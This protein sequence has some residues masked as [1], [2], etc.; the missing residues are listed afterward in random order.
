MAKT[1]EPISVV[2]ATKDIAKTTEPALPDTKEVAET[3][4]D[5]KEV[6][7]TAPGTKEVAETIPDAKE[8]AE[9]APDT[10]E[11]AK[12]IPDTKEVAVTMQPTSKAATNLPKALVPEPSKSETPEAEPKKPSLEPEVKPVEPVPQQI[13]PKIAAP[14][15]PHVS[16]PKAAGP[17]APVDKNAGVQQLPWDGLQALMSQHKERQAQQASQMVEPVVVN[18]STHRKEGMRLKRLMEESSQ[19]AKYPHMKK[20]FTEGSKEAWDLN[21]CCH[22]LNSQSYM[23]TVIDCI[24]FAAGA[25][26]ASEALGAL[27]AQCRSS[28]SAG[29]DRTHQGCDGHQA[30]GALER[31]RDA[32]Q[33]LAE[34]QNRSYREK[35][36]RHS[37]W[38]LSR[39]GGML[40]VLG[41]H[42]IQTGWWGQA[43]P[44]SFDGNAS[45]S[46]W[47]IRGWNLWL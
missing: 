42:W 27:R 40:Q 21:S 39:P 12:T 35:E 44:E 43:V 46:G 7:E 23:H 5:T 13:E 28:G 19:G 30:K 36:P 29:G 18:W 22:V 24:A 10:K 33:R 8:V 16:T 14:A 25:A 20:M 41:P 11:V 6:A 45:T 32:S 38:G 34:S 4:P 47:W 17:A 3:T 2:A 15:T 1:T 37:G 26:K 31:F 9:T